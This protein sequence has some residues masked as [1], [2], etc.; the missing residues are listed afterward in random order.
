MTDS[1][2]HRI[3]YLLHPVTGEVLKVGRSTD[4]KASK[5]AFEKETGIKTVLGI[6]QRYSDLNRASREEY[7]VKAAHWPLYN[8]PNAN[9]NK[10]RGK[11]KSDCIKLMATFLG[12][13]S[14][15]E[16]KL[17]D[18]IKRYKKTDKN[19]APLT[20]EKVSLEGKTK[21]RVEVIE[22]NK[23]PAEVVKSALYRWWAEAKE[24]NDKK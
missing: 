8:H 11:V 19:Y 16:F 3:Y 5:A 14:S 15:G 4:E 22:L 12:P 9:S 13:D 21:Y 18:F 7:R 6:S 23:E 10:P 1:P 24:L 20:I 17:D 2:L